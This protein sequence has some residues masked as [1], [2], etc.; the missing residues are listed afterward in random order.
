M[1]LKQKFRSA[2]NLELLVVLSFSFLN[3][4]PCVIKVQSVS[5]NSEPGAD[6]NVGLHSSPEGGSSAFMQLPFFS[7]SFSKVNMACVIDFVLP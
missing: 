7:K 6:Q 4:Y 5:L 1:L 2:K 3:L